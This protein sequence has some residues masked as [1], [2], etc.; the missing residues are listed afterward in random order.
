M[1]LSAYGKIKKNKETNN[2]ES[3]QYYQYE[4]N[5]TAIFIK[6]HMILAVRSGPKALIDFIVDNFYNTSGKLNVIMMLREGGVLGHDIKPLT[7]IE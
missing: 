3:Q 7:S 1:L 6:L 5:S 4:L 2:V